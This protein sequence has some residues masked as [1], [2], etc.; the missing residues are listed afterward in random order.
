M[1]APSRRSRSCWAV[2]AVALTVFLRPAPAHQPEPT[3][4]AAVK[5][6][7]GTIVFLS[8]TPDAADPQLDGVLLSPHEY[9]TLLDQ[10]E[11][12]KA[13][14]ANPK[15]QPPSRCQISGKVEARGARV[16]ATLSLVYQFRTTAPRSVIALGTRGAF[17]IA[18]K[19][20]DGKLPVLR[21]GDEGLALFVEAAGEHALTLEVEVPVGPRGTKGEPG[22]EIT[23]PRAAITTLALTPPTNVKKVTVGVRTAI[24]RPNEFKQTTEDVAALTA[25]VDRAGYPL[26]PAEALSL[27]WDAPTPG[28][29]AV[30]G[31]ATADADVTVRVSESQIETVALLR[32]RG[33]ASEWTFVFPPGAVVTAERAGTLPKA[34]DLPFAAP[35][36]VRQPDPT[37]PLWTFRPP[38]GM[39]ADWLVTVVVRQ[40]RDPKSR[41]PFAVG[42]FAVPTAARQSG[43]VKVFAP[44]TIALRVKPG[45]DAHRPEMQPPED[46]LRDLFKYVTVL[47]TRQPVPLL[48]LVDVRPA[49]PIV[50]VQPTFALR[51]A[52]GGWRLD[53]TLAITPVRTEVSEVVVELPPGWQGLEVTPAELVD[54]VQEGKET[55]TGRQYSVQLATSQKA[56][57]LTL[58]ANFA[59]ELTST[60]KA[61]FPLP[62]FPGLSVQNAKVT[63]TVPDGLAVSGT[64]TTEGGARELRSPNPPGAKPSAVTAVSGQ[65]EKGV[66]RVDLAWHPHRPELAIDILADVVVNERQLLVKQVIRV[67]SPE[68]EPRPIEFVGPPGAM[69]LRTVPSQDQPSANAWKLRPPPDAREFTQTVTYALPIPPRRPDQP[70]RVNVGLF[71]TAA[72]PKTE[73]TIRIVGGSGR[74]IAR[75]E[76]LWRELPPEPIAERDSLPWLTLAGTGSDLPLTLELADADGL[77]PTTTVDRALMQAWVDADGK[78]GVRGRFLLRRWS[79]LLEVEIPAGVA[80]EF[81]VDGKKIDPSV[82]AARTV[83]LALPEAKP[84]GAALVLDVRYLL[85]VTHTGFGELV[86]PPPRLPGA[87]YRTSV[88]WQVALPSDA[89]ALSFDRSLQSELHWAWRAGTFAPTAGATTAELDQWLTAGAEPE[90]VS[91]RVFVAGTDVLTARQHAV[92]EVRLYHVPRALWVVGCS[93]VVLL[94][95]LAVS[96]VRPVLLGPVLGLAGIAAVITAMA[97]PQPTAHAAGAALPGVAALVIVL[98]ASAA[99]RW[100]YRRRIT[101]LPGFTRGLP[102]PPSQPSGS[103]AVVIDEP[104]SSR[105][106]LASTGS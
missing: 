73:A 49:P 78:V 7:D 91:D 14:K 88:R 84:G 18:A 95:G 58:T 36:V 23:L 47:A 41:G 90:A 59:V 4:A 13:L 17:P 35:G 22:F 68:G 3:K 33:P 93:L 2:I 71:W 21:D 104:G 32:L 101:H 67:R 8:K 26:G 105:P 70:V 28:P 6:P 16:I 38:D 46:E 102:E 45:P 85:P 106:P 86:L 40:S 19:L 12:F 31:A 27:T 39:G 15:A 66:T 56:F 80:P 87:V 24:D 76:G 89:V 57:T 51:P 44:P 50:R 83:R 62:R 60:Q 92:A 99:V 29:N 42:P 5:L 72:A 34:E 81:S 63:A 100:Y 25:K 61:T 53:A 30:E 11:Q 98:A 10:L 48:E 103:A 74:R 96:R 77:L 37:K 55:P 64:A 79:S 9:K 82:T 52:D 1:L 43:T 65:F 54:A 94:A 75:Y 97:W 69:G 20:G